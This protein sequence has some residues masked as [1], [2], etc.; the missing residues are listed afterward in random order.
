MVGT[1]QSGLPYGYFK[2]KPN[3]DFTIGI[4][5][6]FLDN[7]GNASLTFNDIFNTQKTK[8]SLNN[9]SIN[10]YTLDNNQKTQKI[11]F[12]ISFRFGQSKASKARKV[13]E[14][15]EG[16]RVGTSN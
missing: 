13:G 2:V 1:Y 6:G 8:I 11:T 9:G 3:G 4:K 10:N 12:T 5:K 14:L 15:E 7:R 16:S